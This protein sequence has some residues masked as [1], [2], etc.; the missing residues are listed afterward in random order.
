M[1]PIQTNATLFQNATFLT[2]DDQ[3][4]SA[5]ALLSRNGRVEAVG[6]E[7][8][9][10]ARA[11]EA[12]TVDLGGRV[13]LPGFVDAHNHFSL[14]S[15]EPISI[16]C[17][18]AVAPSLTALLERVRDAVAASASG[19]WL[20]GHGYDE[21][22]LGGRHPTR[23]ELDGAAPDNPLMLVHWS[24]HRVAANTAALA[25]AALLGGTLDPP[26]GWI[27]RDATGE[28]RGLLYESATNTVQ[29]ASLI[30]YAERFAADLPALFGANARVQLSHGITALGDAYVHPALEAVYRATTL[31]LTV[32]PFRGSEAGLIA[33]PDDAI[34]PAEDS[35]TR[36]GLLSPGVKFFLDGGGN[37]TAA[38]LASGR[39]P[40]FLFY[41]QDD[42]NALVA[43]AHAAGMPVALHAAGDIA[44][45]MALDAVEHARRLYPAQ[46]PRFRIEHAIT[47]KERDIP[48]LRAFD[49]AV[50]TQPGALYHAG[51]RL[52]AAPLAPGVRIAPWRA[53]LDAG[54]TLAI[55]SDSPCYALSPLWHIWCAI[56]R[57]T[58]SSAAFNDGQELTV[59]EALAAATR[60]GA[61]AL[62]D[63]DGGTLR[64]GARADFVLLARDPR[65]LAE[66]EWS[67]LT[68]AQTYVGGVL[69]PASDRTIR[70]PGRMPG[71]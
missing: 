20:R 53:L 15:L 69:Q 41:K 10:R 30:E 29:R 33:P 43:R 5:P 59:E 45:T 64:P 23:V 57:L 2:M 31:P 25:A 35:V 62:F 56:T 16:D 17:R 19:H 63:L 32:R 22:A 55:S 61:A 14:T 42:L 40:R 39:P 3:R 70:T 51:A 34:H 24:M 38:S 54:V 68:V 67:T 65:R 21:A 28:P 66:G 52:A 60:E 44:V 46:R 71:W 49:V 36:P 12:I 27:V 58:E 4:P 50:V 7:A 9:L 1:N 48:R 26:G 13:A 37:T 6:E 8:A 47:I 18:P 11:P